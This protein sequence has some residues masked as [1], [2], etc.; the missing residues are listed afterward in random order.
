MDGN[1]STYSFL[2]D[3]PVYSLIDSAESQIWLPVSACDGFAKF[4]NLTYDNATDLYLVDPDTR[5]QL[6]ARN[7]T[8]T[9]GLGRTSNPLERVSI[10]LPYSAF[11]Q[12]ASYPIYPNATNYFPI[13]R[14][15]NDS[16]YTLGRTLL[17]EA[18][19]KVDY[20]R[21]SFSVHQAVFPT[22]NE[23]SIVEIRPKGAAGQAKKLGK[24]A[25]AGV[26]VGIV[27]FIALA[28]F[29]FWFV[30][31]R[32]R[33]AKPEEQPVV[34]QVHVESEDSAKFEPDG[35]AIFEKDGQPFAEMEDS[36]PSEMN[37]SEQLN[38]R[39]GQRNANEAMQPTALSPVPEIYEMAANRSRDRGLHEDAPKRWDS[40]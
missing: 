27:A 1:N 32:H 10:V 14:A 19:L 4:F 24:G 31:R 33:R 35:D 7:P 8:I 28:L 30:R 23:Q 13:R 37:G 25:I 3:G 26:V 6:Q 2:Q 16:Q 18:Y 22:A 38:S 12:Q 21:E 11:D 9:F 29:A 40:P 39:A 20:E 36:V 17:Q 15:Y 5:K 34:E